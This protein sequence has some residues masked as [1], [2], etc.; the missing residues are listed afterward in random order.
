MEKAQFLRLVAQGVDEGF[1]A[2]ISIELGNRPKLLV[3][4]LRSWRTWASFFG[5]NHANGDRKSSPTESGRERISI[6]GSGVEVVF[7]R[8]VPVGT[9]AAKQA[10]L[11]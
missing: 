3:K 4:D 1:S 7:H 9:E 2:P 11:G 10:A 8:D 5:I 6:V